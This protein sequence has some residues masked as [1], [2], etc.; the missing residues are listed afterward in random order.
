MEKAVSA[1][2]AKKSK[3]FEAQKLGSDVETAMFKNN[4]SLYTLLF[5]ILS[6]LQER[7]SPSM[8]F[9]AFRCQR[10]MDKS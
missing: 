3:T 6:P 4:S 9:P 5:L 2:T 10:S 7:D 1:A 8:L